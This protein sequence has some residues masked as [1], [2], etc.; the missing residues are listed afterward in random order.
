MDSNKGISVSKTGEMRWVEVTPCECRVIYTEIAEN[1]R[2]CR[3]V[4]HR[5]E[6]QR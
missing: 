5:G 1:W 4:A 2:A 6:P 3:L